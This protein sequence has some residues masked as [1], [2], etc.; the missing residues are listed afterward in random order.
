[1]IDDL[2]LSSACSIRVSYEIAFAYVLFLLGLVCAHV[3]IFT[4][5]ETKCLVGNGNKRSYVSGLIMLWG[6]CVLGAYVATRTYVFPWYEPLY[7]VPVLL[8]IGITILGIRSRF[9]LLGLVVFAIPMLGQMLGL[10]QVILAA[11]VNPACYQDFES[12]ARVRHYVQ[13]GNW[14]YDQ[15]PRATLMTS[16]IGGLGYGFKGHMVDGAGL[17]SPDALQY[18]PM[19]VPDERSAGYI[20][21]IPVGFIEDTNPE[22]IVSYDVFAEAFLESDALDR[23]VRFKYPVFLEEDFKRS[24]ISTLWGSEYLNVFIREDLAPDSAAGIP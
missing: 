8:V 18:H 12:G 6:V 16:E 23:Y 15:Y 24:G 14:L 19:S 17:I 7:E 9:A 21:A 20:G 13:I 5:R 11:S 3:G 2:P 10:S 4:F 1:L 22:L